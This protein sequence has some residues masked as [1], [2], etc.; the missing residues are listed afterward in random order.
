MKK[1]LLH[2]KLVGFQREIIHLTEALLQEKK[3]CQDAQ[4]CVFQ[5]LLTILDAFENVFAHLTEK[6]ADFD[7]TTQRA[8]KS[9]R[10]IHRKLLRLL[11][12]QDVV[13]IEFTEGQIP[14]ME[15]C[16]VVETHPAQGRMEAE[17]LSIIKNGYRRGDRVFRPAEVITVANQTQRQ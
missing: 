17:V 2:H 15:W 7:K 3:Q 6:E 5:E 11:E 12:G 1:E 16:Q 4:A 10:A 8:I 9:F 13:K 14:P